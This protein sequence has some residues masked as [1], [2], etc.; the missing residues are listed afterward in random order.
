MAYGKRYIKMTSNLQV[1]VL[2]D[3]L[4]KTVSRGAPVT[5][6]QDSSLLGRENFVGLFGTRLNA[7]M[8]MA[9]CVLPPN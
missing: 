6:E 3:W 7:L 8:E 9:I 1:L 4:P 5:A 2:R